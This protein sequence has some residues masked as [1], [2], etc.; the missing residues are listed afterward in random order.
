MNNTKVDLVVV[1]GSK[2]L[3][4]FYELFKSIEKNWNPVNTSVVHVYV[5]SKDNFYV[6]KIL[7]QSINQRITYQKY[8]R[9]FESGNLS[10][11]SYLTQ[12]ILKMNV[13]LKSNSDFLWFLDCDYLLAKNNTEKTL[14]KDEITHLALPFNSSTDFVWLQDSMGL[15]G[16]PIE[17]NYMFDG[18][19]LY[20]TSTL[21]ELANRLKVS[22]YELYPNFS[23]F[24]VMGQYVRNHPDSKNV[25][26]VDSESASRS[27]YLNQNSN[28]GAIKLSNYS[29][30]LEASDLDAIILWSHW[31][32]C[33]RVM[34]FLNSKIHSHT[35]ESYV[36]S[37]DFYRYRVFHDLYRFQ[38]N[39]IISEYFSYSD[40][41][42]YSEIYFKSHFLL[43]FK[44]IEI[45]PGVEMNV[46]VNLFFSKF[47]LRVR[48]KTL[49]NFLLFPIRV[50]FIIKFSNGTFEQGTGRKL[51][52]R[53]KS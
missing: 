40:G 27:R 19:N 31:D 52:A 44:K 14:V 24:Y 12:R 47:W 42:L 33:A 37:I 15:L 17:A 4:I 2:D 8:I 23:E 46:Y 25:I 6:K 50:K 34:N 11:N 3:E 32:E 41:W 30:I 16:E 22:D 1:V 51:Y 18:W 38:E 9:E 49:L 21:K 20:P 39:K 35:L 10:N 5:H 53:L 45:L 29:E 48:S 28:S 36:D 43:N 13:A 26:Y 7:N